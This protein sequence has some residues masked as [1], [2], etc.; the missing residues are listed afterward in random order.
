M[1]ITH[2][3]FAYGVQISIFAG[4]A[5]VFAVIGADQNIYASSPAEK[6][7]G[8][9]WI[10]TA[11]ID[12]LWIIYFTSPSDSHFTRSLKS[13]WRSHQKAAEHVQNSQD[14][15]VTPPQNGS[16]D[17]R[18]GADGL[19][20]VGLNTGEYATLA[21]GDIDKLKEEEIRGPERTSGYNL[22]NTQQRGSRNKSTWSNYTPSSQ[23]GPRTTVSSE[24]TD[25]ARSAE[26]ENSVLGS[27]RQTLVKPEPEPAN[28]SPPQTPSQHPP[29][30]K[31]THSRTSRTAPQPSQPPNE[32]QWRAEALFDCEFDDIFSGPSF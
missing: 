3:T 9:G 28:L 6:A 29:N 21:P 2:N 14:V 7:V 20:G 22:D 13:S 23:Q 30:L 31:A 18:S 16:T 1:V 11:I 25:A 24:G 10:I 19:N 15:F 17:P 8:A 26:K 4:L 32:A 5:T 27:K 12:L